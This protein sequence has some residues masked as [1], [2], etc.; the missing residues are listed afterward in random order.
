MIL[1]S[2]L[3]IHKYISDYVYICITNIDYAYGTFVI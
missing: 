3:Y 1:K 2:L